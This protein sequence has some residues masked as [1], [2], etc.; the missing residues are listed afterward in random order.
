MFF[1]VYEKFH[2]KFFSLKIS[3]DNRFLRQIRHNRN[4]ERDLMKNVPDWEVGT[5]WG[6]KVY[7]TIPD[8]SLPNVSLRE[9]Y[10]HRS[11]TEIREFIK[12]NRDTGLEE[13]TI[14]SLE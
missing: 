9:F 12:P 3:F 11:L 10:A 6:S 4:V 13:N 2:A 7:K 1:F 5:L 8:N 14:N